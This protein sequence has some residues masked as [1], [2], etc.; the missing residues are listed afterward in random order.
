MKQMNITLSPI[1]WIKA[2]VFHRYPKCGTRLIRRVA[3]D[4]SYTVSGVNP[5]SLPIG[6]PVGGGISRGVRIKRMRIPVYLECP[7][8][9]LHIRMKDID[10]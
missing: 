7:K 8:C 4:E 2:H 1:G 6:K 9:G 3:I 5:V 10:S